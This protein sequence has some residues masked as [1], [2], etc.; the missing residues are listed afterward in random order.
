MIPT[1]LPMLATSSKPFDSHDYIFEV[2]WDGVRALAATE[3]RGWR[4]WGRD[5][6]DYSQRYPEMEVLRRLPGGTVVD[7]ELVVFQKDGCTDFNALLGRHQLVHQRRIGHAA[8]QLPVHYMVFDVLY[9]HG[10]SLLNEPFFRRRRILVDLIVD[11]DEPAVKFSEGIAGLGEEL[12]ERVTAQGHEGVMAKQQRSRYLPGKRSSAWRKIKPT[13]VIPCLI[14]GY[15]PSRHGFHGLLVAAVH[16]GAFRY[17]GQITSGFSNSAKASLA[18]RLAQR[19]R[20][21]PVVACPCPG[22]WIEPGLYCR[23]QFLQWTPHGHLRGASF[24]GLLE[25]QKQGPGLQWPE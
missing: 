18:Q 6:A 12:F 3:D 21:Q 17:V 25:E 24:K 1:L 9:E 7:G 23:V 15:T 20:S 5:Q 4:I 22:R 16:E 10:R 11:L 14:I 13:Q 8:R 19:S 2:K